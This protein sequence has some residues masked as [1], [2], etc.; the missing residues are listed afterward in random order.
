MVEKNEKESFKKL[1]ILSAQANLL[2]FLFYIIFAVLILG[3][4]D[5]I[6]ASRFVKE[7]VLMTALRAYLGAGYWYGAMFLVF[8]FPVLMVSTIIY[9][10]AYQRIRI[11]RNLYFFCVSTFVLALTLLGLE[12]FV[13][14]PTRESKPVFLALIASNFL[15]SGISLRYMQAD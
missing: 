7:P 10:L 12:W 9:K 1:L 6:H 4:A 5:F 13:H 2:A 11:F 14:Y 15:A 3:S 8:L